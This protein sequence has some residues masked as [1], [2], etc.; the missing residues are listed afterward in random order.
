MPKTTFTR[1]KGCPTTTAHTPPKPPAAKLRKPAKDFFPTSF[2]F[3]FNSSFD[4][5]T[6]GSLPATP[7]G[8]ESIFWLICVPVEGEVEDMARRGELRTIFCRRQEGCEEFIVVWIKEGCSFSGRR[9]AEA[10]AARLA[11]SRPTGALGKRN[12]WDHLA[13]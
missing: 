7:G 4:S 10:Q 12:F 8:S 9:V 11:F 5:G 2:A 3:S 13:E 1:S 6:W